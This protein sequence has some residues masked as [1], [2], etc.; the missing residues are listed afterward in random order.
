MTSLPSRLPR[1]T[2]RAALALAV[3]VHL[4][5]M[6]GLSWPKVQGAKNGRDFASYY[7][8]VQVAADGQDPY[9]NAALDKAARKDRTRRSVYPFFYPPPYLLTVLWALPMELPQAYSLWFWLDALFL[10]AAVLALLRWRPTPATEWALAVALVAF[11]ALQNNHV[12]GQ[13]NLPVVALVAWGLLLGERDR[14]WLGGGLMGVACMMKMS[15]GLL[16]AWWLIRGRWRPVAAAC[17]V[18]VGVSLLTL[19][20]VGPGDQLRFYTE[21]LPAFSSGDY[22]GLSVSVLLFGNHSIANIWAQIWP[23]GGSLSSQARLASSLT[24]L[25][26]VAVVLGSLRAQRDSLGALCAAGALV[27]LMLVVPAYTYE[28]HLVFLLI[29]MV[30]AAGAL[31]AGRLRW[32]WALGLAPACGWLFWELSSL[33]AWAKSMD[34]VSGLLVQEG[35]FIALAVLGVACWVAARSRRSAPSELAD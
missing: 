31:A 21:V 3:L 16:V 8:A 26:L 1:W 24:T 13:A 9:D 17:G 10:M 30:A 12:M 29:P 33:K 22:H 20:L 28:H 5:L 23:E 14:P 7:Y 15:P 27:T 18:A 32:G 35:K 2:S 6:L 25:P 19:P 34:G 4:G 11:T